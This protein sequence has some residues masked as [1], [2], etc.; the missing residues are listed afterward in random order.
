MIEFEVS[1]SS[2]FEY[3]PKMFR[4]STSK[5]GKFSSTYKSSTR[6]EY[7]YLL[8]TTLVFTQPWHRKITPNF[9]FGYFHIFQ[10]LCPKDPLQLSEQSNI[11]YAADGEGPLE[12]QEEWKKSLR[13]VMCTES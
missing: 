7:E 5:S 13:L 12:L 2:N 6:F 8:V 10:A 9:Y 3:F 4:A 11:S 1:S